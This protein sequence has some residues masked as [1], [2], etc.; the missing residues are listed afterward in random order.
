MS[1]I[2]KYTPTKALDEFVALVMEQKLQSVIGL[3]AKAVK[4]LIKNAIEDV[5]PKK[6]FYYLLSPREYLERFADTMRVNKIPTTMI[7]VE[8][9]SPKFASMDPM[10]V[11]FFNALIVYFVQCQVHTSIDV[12]DLKDDLNYFT[13][14][15]DK[16]KVMEGPFEKTPST[17]FGGKP[18]KLFELG[19]P[20]QHNFLMA[21]N[22]HGAVAA[23]LYYKDKALINY[24]PGSDISDVFG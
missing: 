3:D 16:T 24:I 9:A 18:L 11:M 2:V 12:K 10:S 7:A 20:P 14:L 6:T 15:F 5:F 17:F 19:L 23:M 8:K 13:K 21:Y 22:K 4:K 1:D